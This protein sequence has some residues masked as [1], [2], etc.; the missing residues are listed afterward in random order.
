MKRLTVLLLLLSFALMGCSV[1]SPTAPVAALK[2][3]TTTTSDGGG[4]NGC[5][6]PP[7]GGGG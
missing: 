7:P 6:P 4:C 1:N 2:V 5:P 3:N